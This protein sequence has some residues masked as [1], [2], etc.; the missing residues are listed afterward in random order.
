MEEMA[1][2]IE[3]TLYVA[4]S[5][6]PLFVSICQAIAVNFVNYLNNITWSLTRDQ[7]NHI[8]IFPFK[9]NTQEVSTVVVEMSFIVRLNPVVYSHRIAEKDKSPANQIRVI[10]ITKLFSPSNLELLKILKYLY[11]LSSLSKI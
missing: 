2:G 3:N 9:H 4:A 8:V 10:F 11:F 6:V 5:F 1:P 7:W